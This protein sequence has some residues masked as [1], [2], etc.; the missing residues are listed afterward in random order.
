[1]V[2]FKLASNDI[3]DICQAG[4]RFSPFET[5]IGYLNLAGSIPCEA[6]RMAIDDD[7]AFIHAL[8]LNC[9]GKEQGAVDIFRSIQKASCFQ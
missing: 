1:V 9:G 3:A 2:K 7:L 6:K 8:H 5:L 4:L